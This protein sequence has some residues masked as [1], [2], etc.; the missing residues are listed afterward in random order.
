MREN[1]EKLFKETCVDKEVIFFKK[2]EVIKLHQMLKFSQINDLREQIQDYDQR[3]QIKGNFYSQNVIACL[4]RKYLIHFLGKQD[5]VLN[6][7][8]VT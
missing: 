4:C 1:F 2:N 6:L 8:L 3:N 7:Q 5:T